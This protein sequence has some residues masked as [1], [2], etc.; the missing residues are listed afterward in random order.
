MHA[1]QVILQIVSSGK[2]FA[3]AA[4][5]YFHALPIMPGNFVYAF[6][7]ALAIVGRCKPFLSTTAREA[8]IV[9]LGV[10]LLM[11]PSSCLFQFGCKYRL[12][13]R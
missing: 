10:F 5:V 3:V 4:A 13:Q 6:L 1:S 9:R 12:S 7:V 8:A 11:F 2:H